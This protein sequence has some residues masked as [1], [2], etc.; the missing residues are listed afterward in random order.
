M[1]V[2]TG[3]EVKNTWSNGCMFC[4]LWLYVLYAWLYKNTCSNGCIFFMLGCTFCTLLFNF[5][6]Y[7]FLCYVYVFL[8]LCLCILIFMFM[9]PYC[10]VLSVLVIVFHCFVLCTVCA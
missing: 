3:V 8:L 5:V 4:M 6:Y 1:E 7:V 10:Y 9:Y 2:N